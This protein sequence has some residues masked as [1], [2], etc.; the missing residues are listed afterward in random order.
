MPGYSRLQL[1]GKP[2]L[3]MT[4]LMLAIPPTGTPELVVVHQNIETRTVGEIERAKVESTEQILWP[5]LGS[6]FR[7][8]SSDVGAGHCAPSAP[9]QARTLSGALSGGQSVDPV[10]AFCNRADSFFP[11]PRRIN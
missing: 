3:P 7:S 10:F 2:V 11:H 5:E 9:G 1:P 4:Q 6:G 8:A